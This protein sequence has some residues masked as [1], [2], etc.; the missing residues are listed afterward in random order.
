[1]G[2]F[3][4]TDWINEGGNVVS[5]PGSILASDGGGFPMSTWALGQTVSRFRLGGQLSFSLSIPDTLGVTFEPSVF[6]AGR[7]L[8]SVWA[9]KTGAF[10][11]G[12]PGIGSL[13]PA[14][15]SLDH[16][17]LSLLNEF[18]SADGTD[19]YTGVYEFAGGVRDIDTSRGPG[20]AN[21]GA[22]YLTWNIGNPEFFVPT[23]CPTGVTGFWNTFIWWEVLFVHA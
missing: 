23:D 16:M 11:S 6:A 18:H 3:W 20:E 13:N 14:V 12:A 2:S 19:H 1:M 10:P 8:F 21:P 7:N 5:W 17:N 9:D 22:V 4:A 15:C